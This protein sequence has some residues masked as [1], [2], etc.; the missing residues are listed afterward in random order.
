MRGSALDYADQ[1]IR[2]NCVIP[3]ATD[4]RLIQQYFE[5]TPDPEEARRKLLDSIPMRRLASPEDVA[6]AV[7]FVVS[8]TRRT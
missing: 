1:G 8:I 3:G 2:A 7:L 5:S 6:R 4:T